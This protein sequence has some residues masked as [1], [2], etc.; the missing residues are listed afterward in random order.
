MLNTVPQDAEE[1]GREPH[2]TTRVEPCVP[3]PD[4]IKLQQHLLAGGLFGALSTQGMA[5]PC[6]EDAKES[7]HLGRLASVRS[8]EENRFQCDICKKTF[9]NATHT[10]TPTHTRVHPEPGGA[11][12]GPRVHSRPSSQ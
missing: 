10:H 9:K 12:H 5:F 3:F 4:Y 11:Q 7:E 2:L 1:D 6:F 8:K